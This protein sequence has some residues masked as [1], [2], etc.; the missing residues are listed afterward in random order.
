MKKS[1]ILSFGVCCI[2]AAAGSGYGQ[3][4]S[5]RDIALKVHNSN[6]STTGIVLKG[7]MNLKNLKNG[8]SESRRVVA[9]SVRNG[10]LSKS[11]FRFTD[12]SYSGTTFLTLERSG[13]DN[14]QYLYLRSVGSPRQ[15]EG[16]DREDYFV[17]TDLSNEDL[18]G[19]RV[20]D[21]N[22]KRLPD[23]NIGGKDCYVLERY[24]KNS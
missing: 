1:V 17:D 7:Q 22:Y 11:L 14:L 18:G 20:D 24:P 9:L 19:S 16:S 6:K 12:S 15:V 2:F 8:S 13:R 21:Y 5:G 10:G 3:E 23:K 4:L